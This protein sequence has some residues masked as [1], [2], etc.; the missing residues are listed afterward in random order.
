[1][2]RRYAVALMRHSNG[3]TPTTNAISNHFNIGFPGK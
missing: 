1:M 3:I 2:T